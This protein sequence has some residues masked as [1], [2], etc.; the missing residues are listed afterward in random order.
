MSSGS[1]LVLPSFPE[2]HSA[3]VFGQR[4]CYYDVGQGAPLVLLHGMGGDA[5]EWAFC[6][7]AL[8]ST[9]RVIAPDLLGFG[10]SDK[11]CI[12]Y[13]VEGFV[14]VLARFLQTLEIERTLL[15]G[16]SFGG[17]IAAAFALRFSER[18]DKLVLVDAAGLQ[19][20]SFELPIDLR[21]STRRHMHEVFEYVFY[22]KSLATEEL[23]ELAYQQHLAR[24]DSATIRNLFENLGSRRERLDEEIS[25][26]NVPTLIIW[27][28]QDRMLPASMGR[29]LQQLIKGSR[30]E[31]IA[32]CG[33]LPALEKPA[34]FIRLLANFLQQ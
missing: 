34:E 10:R 3:T 8:S 15:T 17:W 20:G 7:V 18:V 28:E 30:L 23:I 25:E 33:H 31:V 26:L 27:G 2:M 5:D 13:S 9:N 32:E 12:D 11:P 24:G 16:S 21:V 1:G 14:E 4:M 22:D 6:L 19:A 29:E